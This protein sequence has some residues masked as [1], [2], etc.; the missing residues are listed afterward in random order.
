MSDY[1]SIKLPH[2]VV[3]I[4]LPKL[5]TTGATTA[6]AGSTRI[7]EQNNTR[8]TRGGHTR[9]TRDF[10]ITGYPEIAV[11]KLPNGVVNV[12]VETLPAY[13]RKGKGRR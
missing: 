1:I 11:V 6:V 4:L 13:D 2:T 7:T 8:V 12:P 10:T 5:Q 9:V 3:T